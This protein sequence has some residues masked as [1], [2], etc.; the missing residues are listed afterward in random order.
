[1]HDEYIAIFHKLKDK[2]IKEGPTADNKMEVNKT[3]AGWLKSHILTHDK[4]YAAY[5]KSQH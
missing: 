2:Y 5:Y 1:L 3:V 4:E